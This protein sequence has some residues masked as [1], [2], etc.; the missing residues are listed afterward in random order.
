[1]FECPCDD[2]TTIVKVALEYSK[3]QPII[4]HAN[5]TDILS[6][7][8]HHYHNTP[9]LKDIF[10]TEMTRKS[11]HQHRKCYSVREVIS[12]LL[13]RGEPTLPYLLSAHDFTG[14]DATSAIHRFG[15]TSIFKKLENSKRQRNIAD[16]SKDAQNPQSSLV[17]PKIRKKKYDDMI[18]D[19]QPS[20]RWYYH[21]HLEL[22]FTTGS[23]FIMKSK[24]GCS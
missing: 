5:D 16:I 12:Q 2:D 23:G 8:L 20:I 7:F 3:E 6:L 22:Q 13:K 1:M 15:K 4:V 17:L 19:S 10:L 9:D 11:N 14:C 18:M 21:H 24:Y